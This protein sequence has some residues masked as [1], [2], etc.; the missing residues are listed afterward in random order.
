MSVAF[1]SHAKPRAKKPRTWTRKTWAA[2]LLG[3]TLT[4]K[5]GAWWKTFTPDAELVDEGKDTTSMLIANI[6]DGLLVFGGDVDEI[7]LVEVTGVS[8]DGVTLEIR[9]TYAPKP[10]RD[11]AVFVMRRK[12]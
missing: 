6:G 5:R 3:T 12:T 10:V 7:A 4:P 2:T 8:R 11:G 9:T 1:G